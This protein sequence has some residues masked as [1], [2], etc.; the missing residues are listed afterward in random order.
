MSAVDGGPSGSVRKRKEP[1]PWRSSYPLE[2]CYIEV[3]D[4]TIPGLKWE[5]VSGEKLT[6][7]RMPHTFARTDHGSFFCFFFLIFFCDFF[8]DCFCDFFLIF[9][10]YA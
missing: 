10:Y 2:V 4:I 1:E 7:K 3:G 9:F 6:V 5:D 8:C